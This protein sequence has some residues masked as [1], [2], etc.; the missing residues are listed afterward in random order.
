M[1]SK[2]WM[3]KVG[4]TTLCLTKLERTIYIDPTEYKPDVTTDG[5]HIITFASERGGCFTPEFWSSSQ[6]DELT[7]CW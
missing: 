4:P 3:R 2:S 1:R 5:Y 6:G 7:F